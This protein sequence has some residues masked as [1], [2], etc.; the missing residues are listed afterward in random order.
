MISTEE[1]K[2]LVRRFYEEIDKGNIG[3]LDELVAEDYLDHN[4][5]PFPSAASGRERVNA[6]SSSFRRQRLVTITS[7]IRLR[8]ETRW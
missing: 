4:P 8:K 6:N 2:R 1:N 5:A 3:I 7:K